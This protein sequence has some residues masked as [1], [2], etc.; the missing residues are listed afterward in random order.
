MLVSNHSLFDLAVALTQ[1]MFR[2]R[3]FGSK[4]HSNSQSHCSSLCHPE[5][6]SDFGE[7]NILFRSN[8]SPR[9]DSCYRGVKTQSF[10]P[11]QARQVLNAQRLRRPSSPHFTIYQPQLSWLASIMSRA[12]GTGLAVCE[13]S[14][15]STLHPT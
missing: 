14:P 15:I 11:E 13:S 3:I 10:A 9:C 8:N 1:Q 6:V 4:Y 5:E 12:T 7:I 2:G